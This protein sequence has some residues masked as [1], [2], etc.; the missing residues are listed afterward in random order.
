MPEKPKSRRRS[1]PA[2]SRNGKARKPDT[3]LVEKLQSELDMEA[4]T[5]APVD[6]AP[7]LAG[8]QTTEPPSILPREDGA[9]LLYRGKVHSLYGEP[10]AGKGWVAL[11]AAASELEAGERV[12]YVDFEDE[13]STAV[14]RLIALGADPEAIAERFCYLRPDE[15]L[16]SEL[17]KAELEAALEPAPSLVVIDGMTEALA[18]ESIDLNDNTEVAKWI[19]RFPRRVAY[20]TAAAV[21][22]IDH[23]TK[24]GDSRGR[25]AIGAQHK[26][27]GIHAAYSIKPVKPFGRGLNGSSR[28]QVEKDRLG[29]V[30]KHAEER[31]IAEMAFKSAEDGTV[32]LELKPPNPDKWRPTEKMEEISVH[33]EAEPD[34]LSRTAIIRA[35][36]GRDKTTDD[37]IRFLRAEQFIKIESEGK[38]KPNLH[39]SLKPY[40]A[41]VEDAK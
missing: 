14:E 40:R 8:E 4:S 15:P 10:E 2:E 28:I 13:A 5:W 12:V 26:L 25:F 22:I 32:T 20:N 38:G 33:L 23:Q 29:H 37:A 24:D 27:A 1:R 35:V 3:A 6:L 16:Q 11:R 34:G 18:L 39:R 7:I 30:R 36:G 41:P 9:C 19:T 31:V 21:L 17:S